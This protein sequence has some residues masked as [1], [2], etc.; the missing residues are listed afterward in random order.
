MATDSIIPVYP[1]TRCSAPKGTPFPHTPA[2][3]LARRSPASPHATHHD[4]AA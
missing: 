4:L 2:Q 3:R 1:Y